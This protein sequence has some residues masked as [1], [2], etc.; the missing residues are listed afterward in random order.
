MFFTG[1]LVTSANPATDIFASP[2]PEGWRP[3]GRQWFIVMSP[4]GTGMF[5]VNDEGKFI[6]TYV[7]EANIKSSWVVLN[8]I[9]Y[10]AEN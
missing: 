4:K 1:M 5:Q 3:K 10:L 7:G 6:K 2:L 9:T 8:S